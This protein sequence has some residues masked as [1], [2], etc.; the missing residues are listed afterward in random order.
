MTFY[1]IHDKGYGY[2]GMLTLGL[3]NENKVA[4]FLFNVGK[5]S[6]NKIRTMYI[7]RFP[8]KNVSCYLI[9]ATGCYTMQIQDSSSNLHQA[10]FSRTEHKNRMA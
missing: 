5:C 6:F 4:R 8:E 9:E 2:T 3:K 7:V 10:L 1:H